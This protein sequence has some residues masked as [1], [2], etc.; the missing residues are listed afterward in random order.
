MQ[1]VYTTKEVASI[2]RV[3][4]ATVRKWVKQ[5]R[6]QGVKIGRKWTFPEEEVKRVIKEGV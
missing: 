2:F 5:G 1:K 4:A 3:C 6:I